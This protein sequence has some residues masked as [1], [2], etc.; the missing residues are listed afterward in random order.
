MGIFGNDNDDCLGPSFTNKENGNFIIDRGLE[1]EMN[2]GAGVDATYEQAIAAVGLNF[3]QPPQPGWAPP[4]D[5]DFTSKGGFCMTYELSGLDKAENFAMELG[6]N[7]DD[8]SQ[9]DDAHKVPYDAWFHNIPLGD[10]IQVKDFEWSNFEQAGW[11]KPAPWPLSKATSEMR[12]VKIRLKVPSAPY[13]PVGPIKFTLIQ[14]GFKGECDEVACYRDD[15]ECISNG[16]VTPVISR[17]PAVGN[18]SFK[19]AGRTFS[20]AK[21]IAKPVA[22]QVINLQGA[23]VYSQTMSANSIMNLSN[24]PTGIYMLRAPSVGY[25]SKVIL[26]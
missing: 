26:K 11:A 23:I 2:I 6:W 25:T 1:F 7:D 19:Q 8:A 16:V 17:G 21:P 3:S 13:T 5:R 24:L 15:E 10:G 4:T 20:F 14:F 22:V 9:E 18:V 12:A